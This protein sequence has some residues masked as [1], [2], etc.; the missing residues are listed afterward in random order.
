MLWLIGPSLSPRW[1]S[2]RLVLFCPK[3]QKPAL[4][5]EYRQHLL[6]VRGGELGEDLAATGGEDAG[7]GLVEAVAVLDPPDDFGDEVLH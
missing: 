6:P 2:A 5:V 4:L 1:E 3:E 7:R